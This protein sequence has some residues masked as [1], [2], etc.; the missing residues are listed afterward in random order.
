MKK[1]LAIGCLLLLSS[2]VFADWAE[3]FTAT[4]A[5][6]GTDVAVVETL[7]VGVPPLDIVKLTQQ[8]GEVAPAEVVKAFYCAGLSGTLV[9]SVADQAGVSS[10]D[11]AAGFRQSL[12]Q[13]GPAAGLNADPF[14]RT[15][16]VA[17][18]N[19]PIGGTP[20]GGTP[21]GGPGRGAGPPAVLPP[22][23]DGGGP[24]PVLPPV[25]PDRF[26]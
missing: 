20:V 16:N 7:K 3:D 17:V 8:T 21:G 1:I 25:S 24:P 11:V 5:Q 2:P 12:V 4:V 10:V 9:N 26:N 22:V 19:T 14:S 18:G 23:I 13:C 6:S 15:T